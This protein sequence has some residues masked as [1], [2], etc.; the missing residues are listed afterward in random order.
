MLINSS[1]VSA[2]AI[3]DPYENTTTA[4]PDGRIEYF[5]TEC[6]VFSEK[7]LVEITD[8]NGTSFLYCSSSQH[9]PGPLT[10]DTVLNET[11][12]ITRRTGFL[13]FP[14]QRKVDNTGHPL[15]F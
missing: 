15:L 3:V 8:I 6:Q 12:G 11:T 4:V 9:N 7:I 1:F 14:D 13:H 2:P 5:L 10:P